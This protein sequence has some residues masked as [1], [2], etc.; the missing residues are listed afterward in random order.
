[1]LGDLRVLRT[2]RRAAARLRARRAAGRSSTRSA[3]ALDRLATPSCTSARVQQA[4][5][6]LDRPE[7]RDASPARTACPTTSTQRRRDARAAPPVRLVATD[8]GVDV[9]LR[10]RGR[11]RACAPRW[12]RRAPPRWP[13]PPP[14]SLRV[15]SGRPRYGVDLDDIVIPQEAGLNERAVS[16]TKGCYVGQETVARLH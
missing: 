13:R 11:R 5:L 14:R 15:E 7:A 16:F 1:M 3:A 9:L 8:R 4:L 10:G 6:S 12:S 2:E